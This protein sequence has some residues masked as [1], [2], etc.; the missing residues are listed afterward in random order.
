[1]KEFVR[2]LR[3]SF[4]V[5]GRDLFSYAAITAG[6]GIFGILIVLVI[7]V[8]D[9]SGE[10]YGKLGAMLALMF[11]V[12][13]VFFGGIFTVQS[14]FNLAISMGKTR[15]YFV[16]ARYL[17]LA[18]NVLVML[19]VVML[20]DWVEGMLYPAIYPQA[21]CEFSI[22]LLLHN[23]GVL[24][25]IVFGAPALIL[26]FGALLMRFS[27]KFF[28][29]LWALWM[30]LFVGGPRFLTGIRKNPDSIPGRIGLK[31]LD[32]VAGITSVQLTVVLILLAA[33]GLGVA[34]GLFRKQR[35]TL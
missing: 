16:P 31:L 29:V 35:V 22:D 32:F 10:D 19:A 20:V 34:T 1:M 17:E 7:L 4:Q 8:M 33:A 12:I 24:I 18:L 27:T 26:L 28:W 14:E 9:G 5:H 3:Q 21:V 2:T 23:G 30:I 25:G 11:G 6:G 15:K 13:L